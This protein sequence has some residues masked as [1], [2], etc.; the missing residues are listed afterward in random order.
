MNNR[1]IVVRQLYEQA[2]AQSDYLQNGMSEFLPDSRIGRL[3]LSVTNEYCDYDFDTVEI[4]TIE[5]PVPQTVVDAFDRHVWFSQ[6]C[7]AEIYVLKLPVA[8]QDTY[9]IAVLGLVSDG[10]DN[11]CKF[12]E[13]FDSSG[14]FVGAIDVQSEILNW[15]DRPF[16]G[17]DFP[18]PTPLWSERES[19]ESS[20]P[21]LWSQ[22]TA[23]QVEQSGGVTRLSFYI[24]E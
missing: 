17:D 18:T 16:D 10:W 2:I 11:A 4:D 23:T 12:L 1:Q 6:Y 21:P 13:I 15:R 24:E 9:A 19:G 5:Q 20:H 3:E 14:E 7:L 8:N 22:A